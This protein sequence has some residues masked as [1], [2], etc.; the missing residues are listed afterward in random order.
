MTNLEASRK[1]RTLTQATLAF[2]AQLSQGEISRYERRRAMPSA[3]ALDRLAGVLKVPADRLL[4]EADDA[5]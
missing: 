2:L 3:R 1:R 5:R 4:D